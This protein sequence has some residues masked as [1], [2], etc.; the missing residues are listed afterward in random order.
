MVAIDDRRGL[1][2]NPRLTR[3]TRPHRTYNDIDAVC[4]HQTACLMAHKQW[5]HLNAHIGIP[6]TG[7]EFI[8][9]NPFD[10]FIWHAQGLSGRSI[11]IEVE[12]NFR[13]IARRPDTLWVN[14]CPGCTRID[15]TVS[16]A[17][18]DALWA[19]LDYC[20]MS[21]REHN[22]D[23]QY[24]FAHRQAY[25]NRR[26]DPGS[27]IWALVIQWAHEHGLNR[28]FF[29]GGAGWHVGTGRPIPREWDSE[30]I[31]AY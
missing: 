14:T 6:K 10:L 18:R 2:D 20:Q 7:Q 31:A 4:I 28:E 3:T 5:N 11:G 23:L 17:Q 30:R 12:G 16:N 27:E 15:S 26:A 29:D 9:V 13:G 21:L 1:H 22:R 24:I 25:K 8:L 19:A